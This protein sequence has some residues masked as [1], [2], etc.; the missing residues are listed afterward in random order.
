M[1]ESKPSIESEK[2]RKYFL[3]EMQ[4][5]G[6]YR[7]H[8]RRQSHPRICQNFWQFFGKDPQPQSSLIAQIWW[9]WQGMN[10]RL[11]I[12]SRVINS[13]PSPIRQILI[14]ANTAAVQKGLSQIG[15]FGNFSFIHG[16]IVYILIPVW[17]VLLTPWLRLKL[18]KKLF[19]S[20]L[21]CSIIFPLCFA[22]RNPFS[23][24]SQV[25]GSDPFVFPCSQF[26]L[27]CRLWYIRDSH[28]RDC[29]KLCCNE[30]VMRHE[31]LQSRDGKTWGYWGYIRANFFQA[32]LIFWLYTHKQT[33]NIVVF[34]TVLKA[35]S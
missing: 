7:R 31:R 13:I 27:S 9:L 1:I 22:R 8:C 35:I 25:H 19:L 10:I 5:S 29:A 20:L 6:T 28:C 15:N 14:A 32:V 24:G 30:N 2:A 3:K 34:S 16:G 33:I 18:H 23:F 17:V 21:R 11:Y 26:G 4:A 12:I